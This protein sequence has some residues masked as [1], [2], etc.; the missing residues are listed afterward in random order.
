V[1]AIVAVVALGAGF[2][3]GRLVRSPAELASETA[4]PPDGL[5]TA[6]IEA[7]A[8]TSTVVARADIV[9]SD[10]I[11]INPSA[12]EGVG[13]PVVTGQ[14][15]EVGAVVEAGQVILEVSGSP[16]FILPGAFPAYRA[17]GPGSSGPDVLQLRAAL[18][19]LGLNAGNAES[20]TY[21]LT[22]ANAVK[23]LYENA[24][25]PAPGSED[26]SRAAAVRDARDAVTDAQEARD[27]ATK[28]L[29]A[30]NKAVADAPDAETKEQAQTAADA[31]RSALAQMERSVTRAQEALADAERAAW[32]T[33]P[34]GAV[35]FVTDL[36]RRVD[37]VGVAVGSD[38]A[39]AGGGSIDPYTGQ[40]TE[41]AAVVLSGADIQVTAQVGLDE[42]ALLEVGGPAELAIGAEGLT[43]QIQEICPQAEEGLAGGEVGGGQCEVKITVA[44]LG[45]VNP[46]E[47]VGNVLVTMVV[48]TTSA[49]SLVVPLA[50]VSA[51]TAGNARIEVV[52]GE[53]AH[54]QA[55][56]DQ[57]TRTVGIVPG[58][59][60]EGMVEV[61][62][63][64]ADLKAGDLVVIGRGAAGAAQTA[65]GGAADAADEG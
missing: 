60:A 51:D 16:V 20:K 5:I 8:I 36:P 34:M 15:P 58:L 52:E 43:G 54:D 4:V 55:A 12:P 64:D 61:K 9:F 42:A 13:A 30:A 3:L 59:T 29:A 14:V 65:G 50:A 35:V 24:G 45:Q 48:G 57:P 56:A 63:A 32:T 27:Q 7:R 40:P 28:D 18:A 2:A 26:A 1:L 21:D 19:A 49:D 23:A 31:A 53:L 37:Q 62:Q 17:M 38:L 6:R 33:L 46:E 41:G 10:P 44:D 11:Q 47:M 22:L 39:N 25:Y